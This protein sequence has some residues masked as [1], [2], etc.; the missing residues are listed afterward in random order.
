MQ[1]KKK[2]SLLAKHI[3]LLEDIVMSLP[4]LQ[5]MRKC[6]MEKATALKTV[7]QTWLFPLVRPEVDTGNS[8]DVVFKQEQQI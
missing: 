3:L 7:G 5:R 2:G 4:A 6:H 8:W 1:E